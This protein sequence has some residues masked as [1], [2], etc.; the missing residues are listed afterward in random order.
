M[1]TTANEFLQT[2]ILALGFDGFSGGGGAVIRKIFKKI[3][4]LPRFNDF[5][6]DI[7]SNLFYNYLDLF[8]INNGQFV[9]Q[10]V[11]KVLASLSAVN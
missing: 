4:K 9:G 6:S 3:T 7:F 1:Q 2:Y 10:L 5:V 11:G 8:Q